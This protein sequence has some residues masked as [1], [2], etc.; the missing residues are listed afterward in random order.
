MTA[1]RPVPPRRAR[2]AA[3]VAAAKPEGRRPGARTAVQGGP[4][5]RGLAFAAISIAILAVGLY[6]AGGVFFGQRGDSATE[7]A[8]PMR[9][10]MAGFDP[11]VITAGPGEAVTIDWWNTDGAMHLQGGVHTLVSDSLGVRYA[12]PAESRDVITLTAPMTPG[13]YDFWCDSC[14][15][16]K[17]SPTMHG[18]LRVQAA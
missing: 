2:R 1:R 15:G 5:R 12:L 9:I 14:C 11:G 18:T 17:D 16:G 4:G 13:D 10:S 7:G 8:I 3:S 6:L